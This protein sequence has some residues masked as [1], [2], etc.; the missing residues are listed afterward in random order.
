MRIGIVVP[1]GVDRGGRERV[2]PA[3]LNFID[4]LAR[5][6]SVCVF[7]LRQSPVYERYQLRGATVVNIGRTPG[8]PRGLRLFDR[9][10]RLL[11]NIAREA[12]RFEVLHA[13]F[14]SEPAMLAAAA[15]RVFGIPVI[16]S[17]L[18]GEFVSLPEIQYGD[19][20]RRVSR[21]VVKFSL[22]HS[23]FV[24]APSRYAIAQ[25]PRSD[26]YYLPM[27]VDCGPFRRLDAPPPAPPWRLLHV[28]TLNRVKDQKTLLRAVRL[29]VDRGFDVH[30]EIVGEDTLGGSVQRLAAELRIQDRVTFHGFVAHEDLPA[31]YRRAHLYVHSSLHEGMPWTALEAA[32]GGVPLVGTA[33]GLF[34]DLAPQG[35]IAVEPGNPDALARGIVSALADEPLRHRMAASALQFAREHDADW[36]ASE[37]ERLYRRAQTRVHRAIF[38]GRSSP[39]TS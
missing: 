35:A 2:I 19:Q 36:T 6:H 29:A 37:Y 13:C 39:G 4:R 28:A 12:P 15:G 34:K 26:A 30:L 7:A 18:G 3:F 38:F 1:G 27:G 10:F 14:A 17:A 5:R 11:I 21:A 20:L 9:C 8:V 32:A 16:A 25:C 23:Q 22:R 31:I 33:V 24:T